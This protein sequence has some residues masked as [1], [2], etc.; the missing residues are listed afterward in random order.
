[1]NPKHTMPKPKAVFDK[2]QMLKLNAYAF[3]SG[4][5]D[6]KTKIAIDEKIWSTTD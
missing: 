2:L 6:E 5:I 3:E 4:I 1:M